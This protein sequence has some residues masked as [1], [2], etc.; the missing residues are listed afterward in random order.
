MLIRVTISS[1]KS[2]VHMP[3]T[4]L[5]GNS[6]N[7]VETTWFPVLI[8]LDGTFSGWDKTISP[9]IL[10][11]IQ[12]ATIFTR[13]LRWCALFP[14][15]P[16]AYEGRRNRCRALRTDKRRSTTKDG[17]RW[18]YQTFSD[19]LKVRQIIP[20]NCSLARLTFR[21]VGNRKLHERTVQ[22]FIRQKPKLRLSQEIVQ[23][24]EPVVYKQV[25]FSEQNSATV[26]TPTCGRWFQP[27]SLNIMD[28]NQLAANLPRKSPNDLH[29]TY[30]KFPHL[31]FPG[32]LA[33]A[34]STFW[35]HREIADPT[36]EISAGL[37]MLLLFME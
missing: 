12:R 26:L 8:L 18:R 37:L 9:L 5:V 22:M 25:A 33:Y 23:F 30:Q 11:C 16:T 36:N 24:S 14:Q 35:L 13:I 32:L 28:Q 10:G 20:N 7:Y 6:T 2:P 34:A 29:S 31:P 15:Q 21:S 4:P 3:V 17:I 19:F 1:S 27:Q